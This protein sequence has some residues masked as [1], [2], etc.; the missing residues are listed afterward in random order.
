MTDIHAAVA[1]AAATESASRHQKVIMIFKCKL[2]VAAMTR[3]SSISL[4]ISKW[5][6]MAISQYQ[7]K[8]FGFPCQHPIIIN[9]SS[10]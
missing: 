4:E 2:A 8:S 5:F 10:K 6:D 9:D 1:V 3:V 7:S